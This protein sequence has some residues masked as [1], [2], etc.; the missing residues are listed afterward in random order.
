MWAGTFG[1]GLALFNK[2]KNQF[3]TF[4]EK[5]GLQNSTV[6]KLVEDKRGLI[7][8]STNKGISSIDVTTKK[9]NNYNHHNGVQNNNF[10]QGDGTLLSNGELFFGGL[11]GFNY[12]NPEYLKKTNTV[13]IVLITDLK[14]SNRS[15]TASEDGPIREHISVAKE[16]NLD[17]KQNFALSF[18]GLDYTAPEQNQYAYKL[19]RFDK[20]WNYVGSST[21]ASY[22]NL[23]P[24]EY[25]FRVKASNNNGVWNN[26]GAS[27]KIYVHPPFW[28]TAYAYIFYAIAISGLVLFLRYKS[29]QR[30]KRR[31]ALKQE[32]KEA[33]RVHELDRLKIKFL[34]NL[35]HEFR[36]PI[37]LILG[38]VDKLLSDDNNQQSFGQLQM[39]KRNGKR[40]LNLV[41][42]LLDFRKMEEDELKINTSEGELI[43]FIKEAADSF[44]DLAERK[45]I[46]FVFKTQIDQFFT[47]FDHDKIERILFNLL[48]NAFKFTLEGGRISLEL[49]KMD[50]AIN[51]SLTWITIKVIDTG[52][53]IPQDKKEKIFE[54]FF[55][56]TTA[57]S[58]LNQGSGIGLSITKEFVKMHGGIIEV[59]SEPGKGTT[60]RIHLP[61]TPMV[62]SELKEAL[63][64]IT[65]YISEPEPV[66]VPAEAINE[67][68]SDK[69]K[70][71][72]PTILLV[73][74]NED[75]RF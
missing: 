1:G 28:R 46:D 12:F 3:I 64:P 58:I 69:S 16:I 51:G 38:P 75:F 23:D 62:P 74:D 67:A 70:A 7:W 25:T 68:N 43:S 44:K 66:E 29:I 63:Q 59:E 30:I 19:E 49:E 53:G 27:I 50:K 42:Q 33:E 6:Y 32:K 57:A 61:F 40:L 20:D 65:E 35:S 39:I 11:E 22:T 54:R 5:D 71:E 45:K 56:N 15:V 21:T 9:I 47:L 73:E 41:N 14:I 72:M 10:V 17:F 2:Y 34:T 18:V 8:L 52:I 37:S 36:T 31:Y 26:E 55:Q 48:S 4:S 13:P 60:F 24:G